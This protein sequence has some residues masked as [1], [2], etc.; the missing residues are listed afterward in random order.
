MWYG[1]VE[2]EQVPTW[3]SASDFAFSLHAPTPNKLFVNPIKNGEYWANGLPILMPMGIGDDS[4]IIEENP[5][6]GVIFDNKTNIINALD[7]MQ[8]LLSKTGIRSQ[9]PDFAVKYR[10]ISI[11]EEVYS[12]V[13][14]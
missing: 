6:S 5:I 10:N 1:V 14:P 7:R 8:K 11:V 4:S 12:K 2:H 3:L 9:I 13:L